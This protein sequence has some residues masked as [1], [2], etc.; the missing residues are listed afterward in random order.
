MKINPQNIK[1]PNANKK[2]LKDDG[3]ITK[4]AEEK[5]KKSRLFKW[6]T[7]G[8]ASVLVV[9]FGLVAYFNQPQEEDAKAYTPVSST[10]SVSQR[11]TIRNQ[12][13][14]IYPV[15]GG[16]TEIVTLSS[17]ETLDLFENA[18]NYYFT[19][20]DPTGSGRQAIADKAGIVYFQDLA[21]YNNANMAKFIL[22]T[23][24]TEYSVV[25]DTVID[26]ISKVSSGSGA[27]YDP[28]T[29]LVKLSQTDYEIIAGGV[30]LETAI[31]EL[32]KFGYNA[33]DLEDDLNIRRNG[34]VAGN[35]DIVDNN[36]SVS[37]SGDV[38]FPDVMHVI[39]G[40]TQ[41]NIPRKLAF[42]NGHASAARFDL[43]VFHVTGNHYQAALFDRDG[44]TMIYPDGSIYQTTNR[45]FAEAIVEPGWFGSFE[46]TAQAQSDLRIDK[47]CT[48]NGSPCAN[49]PDGATVT[50]QLIVTAYNGNVQDVVV[51]DDYPEE[52]ITVTDVYDNGDDDGD[53]LA[54][55]LGDISV[56]NSKTLDYKAVVKNGVPDRTR[57]CNTAMA[58]GVGT[59]I[60]E[61]V[62]C[63][64]T[65][66]S[67]YP[68]LT[69][70]KQC[71]YNGSDCANVPP[72]ATVT[73]QIIVESTGNVIAEDVLVLDDYPQNL[74]D[75]TA[76][77]DN[78]DD[79]NDSLAWE[80]GNMAPGTSKT[81]DYK[82]VVESDVANGIQVCNTAMTAAIG[83]GIAEVEECFYTKVVTPDAEDP[84]LSINK[85]CQYD[86]RACE[87]APVPAGA[88]VTYTIVV[89]N[90]GDGLA[91][92]VVITDEFP[93]E[94]L[95]NPYSIS[96]SGTYSS[97][98]HNITWPQVDITAG[99]SVTRTF[100]ATIKDGQNG[101]SVYNEVYAQA[102]NH[103][104]VEDDHT[105]NILSDTT[106]PVLNIDKECTTNGG[107]ICAN[108]APGTEVN[109]KLTI[110]NSGD[111]DATNVSIYDVY[112]EDKIGGFEYDGFV[113]RTGGGGG[114]C[115]T[116]DTVGCAGWG[117]WT[118]PKNQT[119][120][121]G[122][123]T[124]YK[125]IVKETVTNGETIINTATVYDNDGHE[126]EDNFTFAIRIIT[127]DAPDL[128][129]TK[130]CFRRSDDKP[131]DS[132][133]VVL[134]PGD[135]VKY[136][137]TVTSTG[138]TPVENVT[139]VD[140][141]PEAYL[142]NL[143]FETPNPTDNGDTL[144]WALGTIDN[145]TNNTR[146]LTYYAT[147][148]AD[149]NQ[150]TIRNVAIASG[151]DV[152]DVEME[153]EFTVGGAPILSQSTKT[154]ITLTNKDCSTALPGDWVKYT[155]RV[156]NTGNLTAENVMII[157]TYDN[158]KISDVRNLNPA[159]N[160]DVTQAKI[161][162][163][164]YNILAGGER[165]L[166]FEAR[167]ASDVLN[168]TTQTTIINIA[169]ITANNLPP[170][171]VEN[172]FTIRIV[173]DQPTARTGGIG[174]IIGVIAIA[175][176]GGIGYYL[177][178][179]GKLGKRFAPSRSREEKL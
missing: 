173:P 41:N 139:V 88:E 158:D 8:I 101:G 178:T 32:V 107:V 37:V 70:E 151:D 156:R 69:I 149:T 22:A 147:I 130:E 162:W 82:A 157:D 15:G 99:N 154:C 117:D 174:I 168:D 100:K 95:N 56:N 90:S 142:E 54:W 18:L 72:G 172:R 16:N 68:E 77:Y 176:T 3:K 133:D 71:T 6:L 52:Y 39:S 60:S 143:T 73:Y 138:D 91:D 104:R 160:L 93:Y 114:I 11:Q 7:A 36:G 92:N 17:N 135:Q 175:A 113:P 49:V 106:E 121:T 85:T 62:L 112:E 98:T 124:T 132:V 63:F 97:T 57:I 128:D 67:G 79:D 131:C 118:L 58:G 136:V 137:I 103:G 40:T 10:L 152:A 42:I 167:I 145:T 76:V 5:S 105:F 20:F 129:G 47:T 109:Y 125:A 96:N 14:N 110:W 111:A 27:Y 1:N 48:Y 81:L 59:D 179:H 25:Y 64:Y 148:K 31:T 122:V 46:V 9:S 120:A 177:Y 38:I 12:F 35:L 83:T 55:E 166:T 164:P 127:P 141:Y 163:G 78:G 159:G 26:S 28:H 50:Y 119:K 165:V 21:N 86:S 19:Q 75:I 4:Q 89:R 51:L 34:V 150:Q 87:T 29:T 153:T 80:L 116:D 123:V 155:I 108:L 84:I 43:V 45:N 146:T 140:D 161:T 171:T 61:D 65:S 74:I 94:E 53:T 24:G 66:E 126:A 33:E 2:A 30:T 144:T 13:P 169:N 134:S 170:Q 115:D 102:S 44:E 23:R